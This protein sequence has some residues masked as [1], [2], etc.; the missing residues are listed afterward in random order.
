MAEE[1]NSLT[2]TAAAPA[3]GVCCSLGRGIA[4]GGILKK[5][6]SGEKNTHTPQMPNTHFLVAI[7][8]HTKHTY[9]HTAY[10]KDLLSCSC[11]LTHTHKSRGNSR[12]P[13]NSC[14]I[15]ER[16]GEDSILVRCAN[17]CSLKKTVVLL[18]SFSLTSSLWLPS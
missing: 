4:G 16:T 13:D 17:M 14:E 11:I 7:L 18:A 10:A 5:P 3:A 6:E 8:T 12:V 15:K 9:T 1:G 2:E